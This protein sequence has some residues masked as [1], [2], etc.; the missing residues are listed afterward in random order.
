M[1]ALSEEMT[2]LAGHWVIKNTFTSVQSVGVVN[3]LVLA[4]PL[5]WGVVIGNVTPQGFTADTLILTAGGPS[6]TGAG[7]PV[8]AGTFF[9]ANYRDYGGLPGQSWYAQS[10]LGQDILVC[11]TEILVQQ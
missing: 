7:I 11:V 10:Q 2:A 3:Q 4:N 5:R 9:A 6:K 1:S 8:A